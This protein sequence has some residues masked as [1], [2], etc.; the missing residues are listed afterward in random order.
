MV[1][2]TVQNLVFCFAY[3]ENYKD[4]T[5]L[6]SVADVTGKSFK[7]DPKENVAAAYPIVWTEKAGTLPRPF[8]NQYLI[9]IALDDLNQEN[10]L[11][12]VEG[13]GTLA[14]GRDILLLGDKD[15]K[16]NA[17]GGGLAFFILLKF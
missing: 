13:R 1:E 5:N 16:F 8:P 4:S 9:I 12:T 2:G 11:P 6:K 15:M 10:G 7:A 3:I 17:K 14:C